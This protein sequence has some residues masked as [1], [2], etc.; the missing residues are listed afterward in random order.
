ME[1]IPNFLKPKEEF[2]LLYNL[3]IRKEKHYTHPLPDFLLS[4]DSKLQ[5]REYYLY[6]LYSDN[7]ILAN[8]V[9]C[10]HHPINIMIDE[11]TWTLFPR[12]LLTFKIP[13]KVNIIGK[14]ITSGKGVPLQ[15]RNICLI[16]RE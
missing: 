11:K 3:D 10:L 15:N 6:V 2:I 14:P 1:I 13:K 9:L 16:M 7:E 12:D 8:A 5:L 4:L